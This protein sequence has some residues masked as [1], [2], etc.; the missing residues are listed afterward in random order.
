MNAAKYLCENGHYATVLH[1]VY[2]SCLQLMKYKINHTLHINYEQQ[3]SEA[4][5]H[6]KG[7]T[8]VYLISKITDAIQQKVG[9]S[10]ANNFNRKIKELK[11][12]R[13]NSDY[14]NSAPMSQDKCEIAIQ[15]AEQLILK[16]NKILP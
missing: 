2:Y 9:I 16:I 13:E 8:H 3:V 1:P 4:S 5:K 10:E 15:K 11:Q 6:Y 7:K 14:E 12:F